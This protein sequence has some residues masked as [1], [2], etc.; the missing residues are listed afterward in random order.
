MCV[1]LSVV[2]KSLCLHAELRPTASQVQP[3]RG[4]S[5]NG[6]LAGW[7]ARSLCWSPMAAAV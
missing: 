6:R 2:G 5:V 4:N 7:L 3:Q 1:Y